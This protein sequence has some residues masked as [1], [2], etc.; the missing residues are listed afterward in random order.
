MVKKKKVSA[1]KKS[2]Q[3]S[4]EELIE[5]E[6][7]CFLDMAMKPMPVARIKMIA[8]DLI[9]WIDNCD[10]DKKQGIRINQ[11]YDNYSPK[12][13]E[14]DYYA[15]VEKFPELKKAHNYALSKIAERR[16]VG[17]L[18]GTMNPNTVM[19]YQPIWDKAVIKM[20]E[21]QAQINKQEEQSKM[22]LTVLLN[23]AED[24]DMVPPKKKVE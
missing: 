6:Y 2:I 24:T 21:W 19:K 17:A 4:E 14:S 10:P 23:K 11:F 1:N 3:S 15:W 20:M 7:W 8:R 22:N 18:Y 9:K 13:C 16:E 5:G 12:I